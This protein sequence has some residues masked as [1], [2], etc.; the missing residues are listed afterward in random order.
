MLRK[1]PRPEISGVAEARAE[2]LPRP[3]WSGPFFVADRRLRRPPSCGVIPEGDELAQTNS[4]FFP[5]S[6]FDAF[7]Y[8]SVGVEENGM[9]LSVVSALAR[10]GVDP[11]QEAAR[12]TALPQELAA[13]GLGLLLDR[14]PEGRWRPSDTQAIAVRLVKLLPRVGSPAAQPDQPKTG[15]RKKGN[16]LAT[17]VLVIAMV[18]ASVI[19]GIATRGSPTVNDDQP[20]AAFNTSDTQHGR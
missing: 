10:F 13:S 19:L 8:A 9:E 20:S 15:S 5:R 12:L 3:H 16:R 18:L 2:L 11:W 4:L 6:T 7:L 17:I 14:L 1:G